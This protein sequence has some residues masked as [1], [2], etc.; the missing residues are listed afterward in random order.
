[1]EGFAYDLDISKEDWSG[2]HNRQAIIHR[3]LRAAGMHIGSTLI[4]VDENPDFLTKPFGGFESSA[5]YTLH[6]HTEDD[7]AAFATEWLV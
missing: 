1:M 3:W 4:V 2:L 5:S 7:A 6:F